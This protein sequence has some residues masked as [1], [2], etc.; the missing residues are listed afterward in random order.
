MVSQWSIVILV[1]MA[2]NPSARHVLSLQAE[3]M[4]LTSG[5]SQ[6]ASSFDASPLYPVYSR[7]SHTSEK[8]LSKIWLTRA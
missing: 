2:G 8:Y 1:S 5:H 6:S 4:L 3:P 7:R